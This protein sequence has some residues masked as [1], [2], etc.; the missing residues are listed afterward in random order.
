MNGRDLVFSGVDLFVIGRLGDYGI[1]IRE[2]M[3]NIKE[4]C[5]CYDEVLVDN[6]LGFESN[7]FECWFVMFY[8]EVDDVLFCVWL[9]LK[10]FNYW[11]CCLDFLLL[12]FGGGW[13]GIDI[14]I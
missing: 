7:Y 3:L 1:D 5:N 6:G 14:I 10:G 8:F 2:M 9:L 11:Q 4:C 12:L 13:L